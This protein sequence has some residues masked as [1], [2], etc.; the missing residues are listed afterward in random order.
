MNPGETANDEVTMMVGQSYANQRHGGMAAAIITLTKYSQRAKF[1]PNRT[2]S[3]RFSARSSSTMSLRLFTT[4]IATE[5]NQGANP[6]IN[7]SSATV[8][9]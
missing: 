1:G 5:R 9:V 6:E 3:V 7:T 2:A 8:S 4:R